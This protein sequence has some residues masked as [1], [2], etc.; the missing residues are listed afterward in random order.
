[1][2]STL[3]PLLSKGSPVSHVVRTSRCIE[4]ATSDT[5][6]GICISKMDYITISHIN[7]LMIQRLNGFQAGEEDKFDYRRHGADKKHTK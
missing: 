6:F 2:A 3:G 7:G 4:A 1:M 5:E